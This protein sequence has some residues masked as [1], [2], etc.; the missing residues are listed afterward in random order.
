MTEDFTKNE[1][2]ADAQLLLFR[3]NALYELGLLNAAIT[4]TKEI[5]RFKKRAMF[6][7][8]GARYV[9]GKAYETWVGSPSHARSGS[10]ST[11][12]TPFFEDVAV[13]LGL[14]ATPQPVSPPPARDCSRIAVR[15]QRQEGVKHHSRLNAQ[16]NTAHPALRSWNSASRKMARST[17]G[18][19]S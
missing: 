5:L 13:R 3:A 19:S 11:R 17:V 12:L 15:R 18:R 14:S 2:D 16:G 7:L 6:T 9:R 1:N 10:A 8:L 4:T